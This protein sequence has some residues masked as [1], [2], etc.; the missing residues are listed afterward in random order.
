MG[1][2]KKEENYL[3]VFRGKN[4]VTLYVRY[5]NGFYQKNYSQ[6]QHSIVYKSANAI[7]CSLFKLSTS[8]FH[9]W[10]YL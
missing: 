4:S 10:G 1:W 2:L 5:F 7:P 8:I 6:N 3:L 9:R